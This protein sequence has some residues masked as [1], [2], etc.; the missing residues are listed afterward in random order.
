MPATPRRLTFG[1]NA[2]AYERARPAWPEEAARWLVPDGARFVVELGAGTGKLT[3]ALAALGV[4]VLAV[5]PDPRMLAVLRERGLDGVEGSAEAIPVGDGEADAVVAGSSFHWF[6][7]AAAL[8]EA[9]RVLRPGGRLAFGW[10]HRDPAA[11]GMDRFAR[12]IE[13]ARGGQ[14]RW[15]DRPWPELVARG[16]LFGAVERRRFPHVHELPREALADHLRSYATLAERP[17]AVQRELLAAVERI[18][19]EEPALR[20]GGTLTLPFVVDAYRAR[21]T[22]VGRAGFPSP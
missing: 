8:R 4:R 7:L 9:H 1:A 20:R 16:D 15:G 17:E 18:V 12:A 5:E 11:P 21:V 2:D 14:S 19:D 13:A 10:N 22:R 6:E 3:R